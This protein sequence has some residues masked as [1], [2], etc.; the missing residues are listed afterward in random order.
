M[1]HFKEHSGQLLLRAALLTAIIAVIDWRVSE[2][3]FGFLYLF[4]VCW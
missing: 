2:F 4:P 3:W 1:S